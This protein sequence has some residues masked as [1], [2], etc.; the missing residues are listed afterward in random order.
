MLFI[1]RSLQQTETFQDRVTRCI[2]GY[3]VAE[4]TALFGAV[5]LFLTGGI[6]LYVIGLLL[7]LLAFLVFTPTDTQQ[8]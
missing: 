1:H 5:Y 6:Q 4:G 2:M 8:E 3:A 7:F